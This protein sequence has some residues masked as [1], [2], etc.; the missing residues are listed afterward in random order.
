MYYILSYMYLCN[1]RYSRNDCSAQ[2]FV[3]VTE[4]RVQWYPAY[5]QDGSRDLNAETRKKQEPSLRHWTCKI[6]LTASLLPTLPIKSHK[7]SL[8]ITSHNNCVTSS[9][10]IDLRIVRVQ[11]G[12]LSIV[13]TSLKYGWLHN[14]L[15]LASKCLWLF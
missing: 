5:S 11:L 4:L 8:N 3:R 9:H 10:H 6:T 12:K 7:I 13:K 1:Y 15:S 14:R 2:Q